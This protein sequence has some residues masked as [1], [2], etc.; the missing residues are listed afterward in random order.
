MSNIIRLGGGGGDLDQIQFTQNGTYVAEDYGIDG[1]YRC[2]VEVQPNV[3]QI[4][5]TQDGEYLASTYGIDGFYKVIVETDSEN[6]DRIINNTL[7]TI[8][9]VRGWSTH[10]ERIIKD[11]TNQKYYLQV[12]GAP[13]AV[14]L[15]FAKN[16]DKRGCH[17]DYWN[18]TN[19]SS[20]YAQ[21]K[22]LLIIFIR[23]TARFLIIIRRITYTPQTKLMLKWIVF[24]ET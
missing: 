1:F 23:M 16:S 6:V 17:I 21:G 13:I 10:A 18:F 15:S 14:S 19:S 12:W 22:N 7:E 11:D 3:D 4:K 24:S 8:K 20:G 5:L 2:F 9:T